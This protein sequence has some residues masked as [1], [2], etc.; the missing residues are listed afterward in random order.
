VALV[1]NE[2]APCDY[3]GEMRFGYQST[4][5][6]SGTWTNYVAT[7]CGGI[8]SGIMNPHGHHIVMKGIKFPESDAARQILC[9]H[10]INPYTDC[11]NLTITSNRCHSA[12]YARRVLMELQRVD[13]N[14]GASRSSIVDV[15]L[16]LARVHRDCM[17]G[18]MVD[19]ATDDA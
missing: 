12:S 14:P 18:G 9:K 13:R 16:S 8:T 10:G 6:G 11:A 2:S 1:H 7:K 15:L 17:D 3:C 4:P 5:P 19:P